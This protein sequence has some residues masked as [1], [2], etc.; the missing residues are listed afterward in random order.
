MISAAFKPDLIF[1]RSQIR[2]CAKTK[3]VKKNGKQHER[4]RR[5]EVAGKTC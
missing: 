1:L 5:R 3:T 2:D 4:T